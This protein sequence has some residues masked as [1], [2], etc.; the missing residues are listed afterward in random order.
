MSEVFEYIWEQKSFEKEQELCQLL[1][2]S[3]LR[4]YVERSTGFF[5]DHLQKY[6][7]ARR[8]APIYWPLSTSSGSYSVWLYYHRLT[9]QTLYTIVNQYL[10]PKIEDVQR[11]LTLIEEALPDTLGVD[12]TRLRDELHKL[13]DLLSELLDMKQELLRVAALPYKPDLNDGVIIN[14]APLH[15]LFRHRVWA[16]ACEDC[17]K[18]LEKGDYDWTHMAYNI[19]PDRVRES[20]KK[21]RSLAIAHGLEDICAVPLPEEKKKRKSLKSKA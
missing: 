1:G 20:C 13:R 19:W 4:D 9:D 8:T 5:E 10:E 17:W 18:E 11:V 14:A 12:A 16:K 7:Q 21:D 3:S 2:I 15:K 6:T